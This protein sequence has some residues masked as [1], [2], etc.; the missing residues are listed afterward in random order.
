MSS[1]ASSPGGN[2]RASFWIS[3]CAASRLPSTRSAK[4]CRLRWPSTP[5]LTRWSCC[6]R[7]CA[8]QGASAPR[9]TGSS[10]TV[11]PQR[12]SAP[13]QAPL[14][15][16][17]SRRGNSTSVSRSSLPWACSHNCCMA[18]LPSLPGLP[19]GMRISTIC[20]SANRLRDPPA[21]STSLQS[22]WAPATVCDVRSLN[23]AARAAARIASAA[24]CTSKGSSPCKCKET[25]CPFADAPEAD[26]LRVA[27]LIAQICA[28]RDSPWGRPGGS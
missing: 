23:P 7:R 5:G 27:S 26:R 12:S 15:V 17:L 1:K 11:T 14:R 6:A 9:S 20:L 19:E 4:N 16:A 25:L 3:W 10:A 22:K 13:N 18:A 28:L 24:S 2:S 21:A 8:S